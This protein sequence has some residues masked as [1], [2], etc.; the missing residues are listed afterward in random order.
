MR[1]QLVMRTCFLIGTLLLA[2]CGRSPTIEPGGERLS[3]E[4]QDFL[5][6]YRGYL[7]FDSI[8]PIYEPTFTSADRAEYAADELILGVAL[9]GQAKAYSVTVLRVREMVNDELAGIPILVTW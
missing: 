8:R 4:E 1:A 3:A 5:A 9:A 2:A 7:S 6:S